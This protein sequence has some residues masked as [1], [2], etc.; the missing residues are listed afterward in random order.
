VKLDALSLGELGESPWAAPRKVPPAS[1]PSDC[2]VVIVGA[3]VTGISAAIALAGRHV[4]V[5]VVD[6]K[7]GGGATTRSGGIVLGETLVGPVPGFDRCEERLRDWIASEQVSCDATWPGCLELTRDAGSSAPEIGWFDQG[8][9]RIADQVP[10]GVLDP[11]KLLNGMVS[12]ALRSGVHLVDGMNVDRVEPDGGG[13]RV[14]AGHASIAARQVIMA[15][16]ALSWRQHFDP[17]EQRTITVALQTVVDADLAEAIGLRQPFYTDELPL[18]WGRTLPDG[19]LLFGRELI[20][21]PLPAG[22]GTL[23]AQFVAAGDRLIAR[24]RGLHPRLREI[25]IERVWAGPT[26]RT[27]VGAPALVEDPVL[28]EVVWAGGYGG[29][30]LAQAFV[31]GRAAADWASRRRGGRIKTA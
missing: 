7:I 31:L 25:G 9:I 2:E 30:G 20:A 4:G 28:G 5:T 3:G 6:R 24:V 19:S 12:T 22:T 16:D 15:V 17:W 26:A 11:A 1:P 10:G 27:S 21:W 8:R 23:R 29:H 13:L 18:L 14:T